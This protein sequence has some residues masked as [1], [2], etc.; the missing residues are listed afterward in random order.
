MYAQGVAAK[1]KLAWYGVRTLF[2]LMAI[3]KPKALDRHFDPMSTLVEDRVVLFRADGFDSAIKQAEVDALHYCK[4]T[5]FVNIYGQS[6]RLKF[7][8]AVDAYSLPDDELSGG[9]EVYSST[10][11]SPRS[12]SNAVLVAERFG[13]QEY[14]SPKRYKFMDG[15]ILTEALTAT[16]PADAPPR[17]IRR[18]GK[19]G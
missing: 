17:R 14:R 10:A 12:V 3:G 19:L 1:S 4:R 5:R 15:K 8:H 2:R 13:E 7:L 18:P 9:C 16:K 11:I 6:V